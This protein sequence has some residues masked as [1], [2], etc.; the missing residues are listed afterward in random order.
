M[1]SGNVFGSEFLKMAS[2]LA[3]LFLLTGASWM[4]PSYGAEAEKIAFG[5]ITSGG[6]TVFTEQ[7]TVV[8]RDQVEW[9]DF[10]FRHSGGKTVA[11]PV[12]FVKEMVVAVHLGTRPTA[13]YLVKILEINSTLQNI[14]VKYEEQKP[15]AGCFVAMV[16]THPFQIVKLSRS[17]KEAVFEKVN[18]TKNCR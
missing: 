12:D 17:D 14:I 7:Q 9:E 4:Q 1:L 11:P 5:T 8:I 3:I 16:I 13:G 2:W 15:G 6:G 18:T 10:W